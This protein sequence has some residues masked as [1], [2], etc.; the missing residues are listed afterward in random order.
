MLKIKDIRIALYVCIGL[1]FANGYSQ[2]Y[3]SS[4][5]SRYGVGDMMARTSMAN[6]A[7][8]GVA[9]AFQSPTVINFANP[10]G[11]AAFDSLSCLVDASFSFK[12]HTL[13]GAS[14]SQKGST[15]F[16]DYI[17]VGLPIC[18]W[19][20]TA[21]GYQ[22]F[23]N[24]SYGIYTQD[25]LGEMGAY[26]TSFMGDGGINEV[27]WGNSF[28]LFK[29]FSVGLNA[30]FLFGKYSKM[31]SVKFEDSY[32][33]NTVISRS[34]NVKGAYFTVGAQYLVP[35]KNSRLGFGVTY[36]PSVKLWSKEEY[37]ITTYLGNKEDEILDTLYKEDMLKRVHRMPQIVGGGLS[38]GKPDKYFI[39][40]DFTWSQWSKYTLDGESDSLVDAYKIAIGGNVTP[41][42]LSS[43]YIAR[44]NISFGFSYEMSRL[45]LSD[46]QINRYGINFGL[47]FPMKKGKTTI[48]V[49]LEY[50]QIGTTRANLL[51]ENYF[52]ASI[53]VRLHEKWYQ[54]LKLE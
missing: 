52:S 41:N 29:H 51:K 34:N 22:P 35:I 26:Q 45:K 40:V 36:T 18:K 4:P 11:Y 6:V 48:G 54:R 42:Y 33:V 16:I 44:I 20:R 25:T 1:M 9:Y 5:Y 49:V 28:T 17:S 31:R 30:S 32:A 8:G 50:G 39:G 46:E 19:W 7:M 2:N 43:K 23:S 47:Y 37:L 15:A 53:N 3:L 10:A 12:T 38:W 21:L 27:Y 14:S 24:M 13:R